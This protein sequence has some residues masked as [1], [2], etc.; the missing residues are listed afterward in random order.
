MSLLS[1]LLNGS[2][3]VIDTARS[4]P[5]TFGLRLML[6]DVFAE[7]PFSGQDLGDGNWKFELDGCTYTGGRDGFWVHRGDQKVA[8]NGVRF[9]HRRATLAAI[10]TALEAVKSEI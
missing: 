8:L 3:P 9:T 7:Y 4:R 10:V 6:D 2:T 5:L 1:D